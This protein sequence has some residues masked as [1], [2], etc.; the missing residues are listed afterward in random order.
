MEGKFEQNGC[1][2]DLNADF[3]GFVVRNKNNIIK[4]YTLEKCPTPYDKMRFLC[5][6][7]E[8]DRL[9]FAKLITERALKPL[10][11]VFPDVHKQGYWNGFVPM[12][13]EFF[14][15]HTFQGHATIKIVPTADNGG[16][17]EQT[18]EH[19]QEFQYSTFPINQGFIEA[20]CTFRDFFE[21]RWALCD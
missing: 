10:C 12:E 20:A 19:F 13:G 5:G 8:E 15:Q 9:A 17:I 11:Y 7:Y 4:G 18:L 21:N 1:W 2:S 6:V 3:S 14:P 16:I